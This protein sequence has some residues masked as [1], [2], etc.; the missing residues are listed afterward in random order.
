[1]SYKENLYLKYYVKSVE[2]SLICQESVNNVI[3][4]TAKPVKLSC[5][6]MDTS[7][8]MMLYLSKLSNQK[9]KMLMKETETNN[10]KELKQCDILP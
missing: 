5:K 3:N 9:Y 10:L 2:L 6:E 8:K 7:F 4:A 1:M